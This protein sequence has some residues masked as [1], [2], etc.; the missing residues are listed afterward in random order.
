MEDIRE[1]VIRMQ[2]KMNDHLDDASHPAARA[3]AREVQALED[4]LQVRKNPLTIEGRVK[5]IIEIL[6]GE[7]KDARIMDYSHL[8]MFQDY[9]EELRQKLR[10]MG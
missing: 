2:R 5:H 9:F 10:S 4:D 1:E 6:E 8:D 3:L 7:A